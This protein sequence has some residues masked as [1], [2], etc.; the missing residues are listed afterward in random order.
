MKYPKLRELKEAVR[1]F[2]KPA[3]TINFPKEPSLPKGKFRGQPK[4]YK[5][6]CVGCNA[7]A[8]VCPS[9]TIETKDDIKSRTRTLTLRLDSCLFCGNCQANCITEKGIMLSKDYDLAT[10]D[11]TQSVVSVEKELIVCENCECVIGAKDHLRFL[12][13]KIGVLAYSNPTLI[14]TNQTELKLVDIEGTKKQKTEFDFGIRPPD[15]DMTARPAMFTILCPRCR[16]ASMIKDE[17]G[18]GNSA[19]K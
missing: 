5:D 10:Y 16:R 9:S 11:R 8:W 17:W 4:Y 19:G 18:W 6:D 15:A 12:A 14:L 1:S 3:D 7:C 2:F 13:K